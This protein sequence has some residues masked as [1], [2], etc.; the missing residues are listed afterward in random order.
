M[1]NAIFTQYKELGMRITYEA[2]KEFNEIRK[3]INR[4]FNDERKKVIAKKQKAIIKQLRSP[5]MSF[6]SNGLSRLLADKLETNPE[7][8]CT[9]VENM[10]KEE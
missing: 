5:Y 7:E 10:P 2:I 1:E 8:V 9:R 3:E 6:I 4:E